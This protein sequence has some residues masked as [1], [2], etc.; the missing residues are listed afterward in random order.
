MS[1]R[2]NHYVNLPRSGRSRRVDIC[3]PDRAPVQERDIGPRPDNIWAR[4]AVTIH[5]VFAAGLSTVLTLALRARVVVEVMEASVTTPAALELLWRE[6]IHVIHFQ[7]DPAIARICL[8]FDRGFVFAA[9]EQLLGGNGRAVVPDRRLSHI[10]RSLL[11]VIERHCQEQL[12][13]AWQAHGAAAIEPILAGANRS[14]ADEPFI[15]VALHASVLGHEGSISLAFPVAPFAPL[16]L[17]ALPDD[18]P[19]EMRALLGPASISATELRQLEPGDILTTS[20]PADAGVSLMLEGQ[21]HL[22]G[23]PCALR[24]RKAVR[25]MPKSTA[26]K[27]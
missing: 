20:L 9:L 8:A 22:Q 13:R 10:E 2:A 15:L 23:A 19:I 5:Q 12:A 25:V 3:G 18:L 16:L 21:P 4:G 27:L 17:T 26:D 11:K 6:S 24:G 14:D 7:V 1:Q